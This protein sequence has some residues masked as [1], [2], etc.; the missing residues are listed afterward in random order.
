[1]EFYT[2]ENMA[3]YF[4][5][6]SRLEGIKDKPP[7]HPE[8]NM[9]Q[10]SLQVLNHAMRE[11]NDTDVILAAMLHDIG[12][13]EIGPGH[14]EKAVSV[15]QDLVS[16]KTLWLISEHMRIKTLLNGEMK[17]L[18]KVLELVNH[19]WLPELILLSRWDEMGREPNKI[20]VLDELKIIEQL[21]KKV[22]ERFSK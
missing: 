2:K 11:S 9:M 15:L 7:H 17:R 19:T 1:M 6:L 13:F 5:L 3:F 10:H 16:A 18:T 12:K 4:S 14:E 8:A 22:V 20:I 21:N